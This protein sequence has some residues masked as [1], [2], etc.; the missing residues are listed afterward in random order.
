LIENETNGELATNYYK[1]SN[2]FHGLGEYKCGASNDLWNYYQ[3]NEN[4][5]KVTD[6][7]IL[8]YISGNNILIDICSN[9]NNRENIIMN[10]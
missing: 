6:S 7:I 9:Y 4:G 5:D 2:Y 8:M 1:L 10:N 3:I